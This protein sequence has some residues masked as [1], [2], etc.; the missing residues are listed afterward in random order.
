MEERSVLLARLKTLLHQVRLAVAYPSVHSA[1]GLAGDATELI[2]CLDGL[3]LAAGAGLLKAGFRDLF[4]NW[5]REV[6]PGDSDI[7]EVDAL[8]QGE[9]RFGPFPAGAETSADAEVVQ[10]RLLYR[11]NTLTDTVN[12]L[13]PK[14]VSE[15][16]PMAVSPL[17]TPPAKTEE[18]EATDEAG[19]ATPP[20]HKGNQ[21][22]KEG[23]P[24]AAPE[25]LPP[26][27]PGAREAVLRQLEPSV[28][29]AYLAYQYAETMNK[30][31]LEDREAYDWLKEQ[32][33]DP[34]KGDLGELTD[35]ELPESF[36]TFKRY[37]VTARN[38][39]GESKYTRRAGR[40][41]RS[42][43]PKSAIE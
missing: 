43:A 28:R 12:R 4:A 41:G 37:V 42:I 11:L 10:Q 40:T 14:N 3:G 27:S 24:G 16:F 1:S 17:P 26:A 18:E 35:Y 29:K 23:G 8:V 6:P 33:I 22:E 20:A 21:S 13:C 34:D 5:K 38:G 32:G 39:L 36:E 7:R 15:P 9:E 25:Q 2:E 31:R 30:R 19:S